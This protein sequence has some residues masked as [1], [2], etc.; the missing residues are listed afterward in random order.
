M[1][2]CGFSTTLYRAKLIKNTLISK[3]M[4]LKNDEKSH[5]DQ[6]KRKVKECESLEQIKPEHRLKIRN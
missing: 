4:I 6:L 5:L 1:L 2:Q 3:I